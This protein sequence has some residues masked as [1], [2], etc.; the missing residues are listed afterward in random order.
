MKK[1]QTEFEKQ[2]AEVLTNPKVQAIISEKVESARKLLA[3][4]ALDSILNKKS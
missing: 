4:G 3:T 2:I 1:S